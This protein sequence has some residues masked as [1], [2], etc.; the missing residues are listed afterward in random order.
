[1]SFNQT[2]SSEKLV[3]CYYYC[4]Q[5]FQYFSSLIVQK[6]NAS[7]FFHPEALKSTKRVVQKSFS[8]SKQP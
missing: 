3:N 2:L 7:R 6:S 5:V 1:M 8:G 4:F